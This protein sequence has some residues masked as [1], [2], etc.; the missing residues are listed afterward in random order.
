M[1]IEKRSYDVTKP[2]D[3]VVRQ[4]CGLVQ[5]DDGSEVQVALEEE[6]WRQSIELFVL[7]PRSPK[8]DECVKR[9]WWKHE[10]RKER[11]Y[12]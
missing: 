4:V 9:T 5:A 8:F 2:E 12:H 7:P 10:Q 1:K 11:L 6:C 3:Y